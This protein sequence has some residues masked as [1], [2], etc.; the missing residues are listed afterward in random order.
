MGYKENLQ[1]TLEN[2]QVQLEQSKI[3]LAKLE[4]EFANVKLNPYGITSVDFGKRQELSTDVLVVMYKENDFFFKASSD[5]G[6]TWG[7]ATEPSN[8]GFWTN[9]VEMV[10]INAANDEVL[11]YNIVI[12]ANVS[13]QWGLV[14]LQICA[15]LV[16]C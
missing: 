10:K 16:W 2:V 4:E 1:K 8:F 13:A 11:C 3:E 5:G 9:G 12:I 6:E 7:A 15:R 14:A